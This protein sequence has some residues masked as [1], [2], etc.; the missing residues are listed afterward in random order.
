MAIK[1]LKQLE[2]EEEAD[3]IKKK[4]IFRRVGIIFLSLIV[5][6]GL[7]GLTG[8]GGLYAYREIVSADHQLRI[9]YTE[10]GRFQ[11]NQKIVILLPPKISVQPK[12]NVSFN[13]SYLKNIYVKQI[14][15]APSHVTAKGGKIIYTFLVN[16]THSPVSII[17]L[18]EPQEAGF[19]RAQMNIND[20]YEVLF[21]Q[22]IYQ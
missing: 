2:I 19:L 3:V 22:F 16:P 5:L 7:L 4:N 18:I 21:K 13:S 8:S 12:V 1:K 15:P 6:A 14:I 10:F 20:A 17:F 11:V 9:K